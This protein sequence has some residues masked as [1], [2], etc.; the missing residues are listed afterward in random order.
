[1][2]RAYTKALSFSN[3]INVVDV[4]WYCHTHNDASSDNCSGANSIGLD[5]FL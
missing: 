5:S 4:N 1:M 3:F 2:C